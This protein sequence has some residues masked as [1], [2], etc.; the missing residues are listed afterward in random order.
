MNV[1]KRNRADFKFQNQKCHLGFRNGNVIFIIFSVDFL[2]ALHIISL[3][4]FEK[5]LLIFK[6]NLGH[7]S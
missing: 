7:L 1:S 4:Y 3:I 2:A 6:Q 5:L